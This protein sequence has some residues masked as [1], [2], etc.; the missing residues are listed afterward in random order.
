MQ[1]M[2][3]TDF[4]KDRCFQGERS[5]TSF[6]PITGKFR[7]SFLHNPISSRHFSLKAPYQSNGFF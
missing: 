6:D 3:E 2:K 1:K 7:G 4:S 5:E